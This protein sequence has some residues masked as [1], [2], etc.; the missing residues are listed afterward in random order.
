MLC[1]PVMKEHENI[2]DIYFI[3][4]T[5][6]SPYPIFGL[7][8]GAYGT[9]EDVLTSTG[10]GP[11]WLQKINTTIDVTLG[12]AA[13]HD[14][15][16]IHGDIK[17]S[18]IIIQHHDERQIVAKLIDFA[19]S[20]IADRELYRTNLSPTI[21]TVLWWPPELCVNQEQ[22]DWVAADI[23]S[24]G[25][26]VAS[27]WARG[28]VWQSTKSPSAC[29]LNKFLPKT[30]D[31]SGIRDKLCVM[32][33]Q[34][35]LSPQS[36][37]NR[38]WTVEASI[39][40]ILLM[41]LGALP[42][43]RANMRHLA[44][45]V[46]P[47]LCQLASRRLSNNRYTPINWPKDWENRT[48]EQEEFPNSQY[49]FADPRL[50]KLAYSD[51]RR[52]SRS[53]Y[54]MLGYISGK[55]SPNAEI[56]T[57]HVPL[58][59]T[60]LVYNDENMEFRELA[61]DAYQVARSNLLGLG[62]ACDEELVLDSLYAAAF[63][64]YLPAIFHAP[65]VSR[66]ESTLYPAFIQGYRP[67]LLKVSAMMGSPHSLRELKRHHHDIYTSTLQYLRERRNRIF[68]G[69]KRSH[70]WFSVAM[71]EA[72][73]AYP[74][75]DPGSFSLI[76]ALQSHNPDRAR[77]LITCGVD[78]SIIDDEGLGIFHHLTA[79]EDEAAA[80]LAS[81]CLMHGA[82]ITHKARPI[83]LHQHLAE[84]WPLPWIPLFWA[85]CSGMEAYFEELLRLHTEH[86]IPI[87]Q[88][89]YLL[90][91][92]S[93]THSYRELE[94]LLKIRADHPEL[95]PPIW[96]LD[97]LSRSFGETLPNL[98]P[99]E[100]G[101]ANNPFAISSEAGALDLCFKLCLT[102]LPIT[103]ASLILHGTQ[104]IEAAQRRTMQVILD[105]GVDALE[106]TALKFLIAKDDYESMELICRSLNAQGPQE[107]ESRDELQGWLATLASLTQE[108]GNYNVSPV[109]RHI[110][111]QK[112]ARSMRTECMSELL[113]FCMDCPGIMTSTRSCREDG[114]IRCFEVL[115]S[116]FPHL[117]SWG[118]DLVG[119]PLQRRR[120][121]QVVF[122][123]VKPEVV[124][125][126][127]TIGA[128]AR[129]KNVLF[130]ER[131]LDLGVELDPE[132]SEA[133]PPLWY[134]LKSANFETADLV[135][136]H[137][138]E[139]QRQ[140]INQEHRA[141]GCTMGARVLR[142]WYNEH[143][144]RLLEA[145]DWLKDHGAEQ[146]SCRGFPGWSHFVAGSSN[147]PT[148]LD[149]DLADARLARKLFQC[150]PRQLTEAD[151]DGLQPIHWAAMGGQLEVL[152]TL[153]DLKTDINCQVTRARRVSQTLRG[154]IAEG[155]NT[156]TYRDVDGDDANLADLTDSSL[157]GKTPL[158]MVFYSL[159]MLSRRSEVDE[160]RFFKRG[161]I[162]LE[163]QHRR[164]ARVILFLC[165]HGAQLGNR[166]D[167]VERV[168]AAQAM[169]RLPKLANLFYEMQGVSAAPSL[170]NL[171]FDIQTMLDIYYPMRGERKSAWPRL[172]E[173][174]RTSRPQKEVGFSKRW[175]EVL[176]TKVTLISDDLGRFSRVV[177]AGRET[178]SRK[179]VEEYL[180]PAEAR[181]ICP[182]GYTQWLR[183]TADIR[184]R[185]WRTLI[186]GCPSDAIDEP[187][188]Q[189]WAALHTRGM[190]PIGTDPSIEELPAIGQIFWV[191]RN[192][193]SP[194]AA[195]EMGSALRIMSWNLDPNGGSVVV[196][197][198]SSWSGE[199]AQFANI[200]RSIATSISTKGVF[201]VLIHDDHA[202]IQSITTHD[203]I[204]AGGYIGLA[205]IPVSLFNAQAPI[206]QMAVKI[207][208]RELEED[209]GR[210]HAGD[211][212]SQIAK[213]TQFYDTMKKAVH[214]SGAVESGTD[215][216]ADG[217]PNVME[218]GSY[219][220]LWKKDA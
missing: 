51:L 208:E 85:V 42:V 103:I 142:E 94:R 146:F 18:N 66:Q 170:Q 172:L 59:S 93:V 123:S 83:W 199:T 41:T 100:A 57:E 169:G 52:R 101:M 7:E 14:S 177:M 209:I 153:L 197:F 214:E 32:K 70:I 129:H 148:L 34:S 108:P 124:E 6:D 49:F 31:Q 218:T 97:S 60:F 131:L 134:A 171:E 76:E 186:T 104:G 126:F 58:I 81:L 137:M 113:K 183:K 10:M 193:A 110:V 114:S 29:F 53:I 164:L 189:S 22:V 79:L 25:L 111:R 187:L 176:C 71:L 174:D 11:S 130:L 213:R 135:F 63:G 88:Y 43:Q 77:Q 13:I 166:A 178:V 128:A 149:H 151:V 56:G 67:F 116:Q 188:P 73:E 121:V 191:G 8:L 40:P 210:S 132:G 165:S 162:D 212:A 196:G 205:H 155:V 147:T 47:T 90:L 5:T 61:E 75:E 84:F 106:P 96:N 48:M 109:F 118:N 207:I 98:D 92:C 204:L 125:D 144:M 158:D 44:S 220:F 107:Y 127:T 82:D 35:D 200:G 179:I 23:Y 216:R 17:A 24:Y 145:L 9:L 36:V 89:S 2:C 102:S 198:E 206:V 68:K 69:N 80:S 203:S 215:W 78:A 87:P 217:S 65:L 181:G 202:A 133:L 211:P 122:N 28:E 1:H 138:N 15:G 21:G 46:I 16:L 161:T 156:A 120:L 163:Y 140:A 3:A 39:N 139:K 195:E 105:A 112:L 219:H 54:T 143:D 173:G 72:L 157:L 50:Q 192:W 26:V 185:V 74:A 55:L 4:W 201:K 141:D 86:K 190:R 20:G 150:Y 168:I 91:Y 152:K 95:I 159:N 64:C 38:S 62:T 119:T 19:G 182:T 194:E 154:G 167:S 136:R 180:R 27:I 99:D 117:A 30:L 184:K 12:V 115:L 33:T 37:M 160:H 45:L 175:M